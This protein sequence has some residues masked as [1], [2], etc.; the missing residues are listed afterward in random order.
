[1]DSEFKVMPMKIINGMRI[2]CISIMAVHIPVYFSH[3]L[4]E[5]NMSFESINPLVTQT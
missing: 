1:M 5:N 2:T 4:S 3:A